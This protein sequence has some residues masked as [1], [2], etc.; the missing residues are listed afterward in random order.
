MKKLVLMIMCLACTCTVFSQSNVPFSSTSVVVNNQEVR[1]ETYDSNYSYFKNT[2]SDTTTTFYYLGD[3]YRPIYAQPSSFCRK[4]ASWTPGELIA[5][6][7]KLKNNALTVG[8][9]T[10]LTS[11]TLVGCAFLTRNPTVTTPMCVIG[12]VGFGGG[13]ATIALLATSNRLLQEAGLKMQRMQIS[14]NGLIIK[15]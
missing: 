14:A 7:G 8:I 10:C 15:F 1:M 3:P 6:S 4:Y 12:G 5:R 11:S 2:R 13:I 9:V